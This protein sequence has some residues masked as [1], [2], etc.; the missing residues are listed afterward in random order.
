MNYPEAKFCPR[1]GDTNPLGK[2]S[3]EVKTLVPEELKERLQAMSTIAGVNLSEFVREIL[4]DYIYGHF[5]ALQMKSQGRNREG[6]RQE[7]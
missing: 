3:A 2:N 1:S 6:I 7:F 5:A 4:T